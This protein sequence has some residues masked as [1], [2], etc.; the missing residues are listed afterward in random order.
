MTPQ[1]Q[2]LLTGPALDALRAAFPDALAIY[3]HGSQVQGTETPDSDVDLAVLLPAYASPLHLWEV[4]GS[5][6]DLLGW[7]VDLLD[8]R[9][10]STVMQYQVI[11][12]G[13]RLWS[14]G[15]PTDLFE[16]YVLNEKTNLDSARAPLLADIAATGVVYAR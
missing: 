12:R 2:K 11:T 4:A 1:L 10:A 13:Q 9:A 14:T 5:V 7:S 3:A 6:A 8:L 15:L 16:V